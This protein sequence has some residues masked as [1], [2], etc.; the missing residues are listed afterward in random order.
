MSHMSPPQPQILVL[1]QL[2]QAALAQKAPA[3]RWMTPTSLIPPSGKG[4][5][6]AWETVGVYHYSALA[7][8]TLHAL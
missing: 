1:S 6:N 3:D 8:F 5:L 2:S 4:K 7:D